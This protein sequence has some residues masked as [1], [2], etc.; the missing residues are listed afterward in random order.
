M[1]PFLKGGIRR[2]LLFWNL[3]LFGLVL[4]GIIVA[5]YFY[6]VSQIRRDKSQLQAELAS[7]TASQIDAFVNRKVERLADTALAMSLYPLGDKA[8]HLLAILLLKNDQALTDAAV[9]D[10][11]GMEVVKVSERKIHTPAELSDQSRSE[12]FHQAV[13]GG[14]YI[15]SVYTSDKAEPYV[16]L[17]VPLKAPSQEII[18]ILSAEANLKF[19]W[20][21]IG[22]VRFGT[23][24]YAYLVDRG[25]N[26]IAHKDPTLVLRKMNLSQVRKVQEFIRQPA[27]ADA[28]P[29]YEGLGLMGTPVLSTYAPLRELGWAIVFEEPLDAA[30]ANVNRVR[31]YAWMLLALGLFVATVLMIWFSKKITGPIRAL[32]RGAEIIGSGNLDHRVEIKTADEIESLADEFNRMAKELK[33]SQSTLEQ[34]VKQR[35][36]ALAALYDVTTTVNQSLE[37]EPVLQEV[38]QK[39]TGIFNFDAT[40]VLLFN[41]SMNELHLRASF[42]TAPEFAGRVSVMERGQGISGRVAETGESMIFEDLQNDP[43]Y[44]QLSHTKSNQEAELRFL[45]VFPIKAKASCVGILRCVGR[46]S[47]HLSANEIQLLTSMTNQIGVAVE[48]S[49]LFAD[50]SDKSTALQ[51]ANHEL[52]EANRIKSEFMAAMSHELRT[53]LNIIMGNVELMKD[54]FFGEITEGQEKSLT[55]VSHHAKV[56]LT[57]INNVLTVTKMEAKKMPVEFATIEV[58][59][60]LS[61]VKTYT[62]QLSRYGHLEILWKVEPNLPPITT[63]ALKLEE[64]L[65]NLVGNAYKFTPKGKIEIRVRNLADEEK[66]EFGVADS[67]VG[68]E[69]HDLRQIFEEF[70]QLKEAHTGHFDGFG[71]GLN[72]V[73][74]YLELIHGDIRVESRLGVG[75]TFTFTLPYSPQTL[76]SCSAPQEPPAPRRENIA[77]GQFPDPAAC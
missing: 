76:R 12:N 33:V 60:V 35:T 26:L 43:R 7:V 20:E 25:G 62:D 64:I 22:D 74:K 68:I 1:I 24:G 73:K 75:S 70:H 27:L 18:G 69:D 53:P 11:D 21:V 37:L 32:H 54:K 31:R 34:R 40:R 59:D 77:D 28:T 52:Q 2:R 72:I 71:L 17:A 57:L 48:N 45:A 58:E 63:D 10:S 16:T 6:N 9:L 56:L 4:S 61:H 5:G 41:A 50:V 66:I 23:A 65:Q 30:L 39:I 3:S 38:I 47:R 55:Q 51:Q 8:Q 46:E 15:S 13:K 49:N 67:G 29:G 14:T 42:E 44:R 36:Q 19:L